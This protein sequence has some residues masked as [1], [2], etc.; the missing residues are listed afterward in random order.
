M[1]Y[2]IRGMFFSFIPLGVYVLC[3]C[4]PRAA[5]AR[6]RATARAE[7]FSVATACAFNAWLS[8]FIYFNAFAWIKARARGLKIDVHVGGSHQKK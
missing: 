4:C 2:I 6:L 3:T 1:E 5:R 8:I 7:T